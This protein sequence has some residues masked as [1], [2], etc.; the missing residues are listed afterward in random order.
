MHI[1]SVIED[2]LSEHFSPEHLEVLNESHQHNV[3]AGSETHFK[4]VLV[5]PKFHGERL[6]NRHRAVNKVLREEL[7]NHIHALALHTYT[8]SEWHGL[9]GE[10]PDSPRCLGGERQAS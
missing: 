10:T 5:S 6:I 9:Y 8:D 7:A 2:K 3:A 1:Q 4:V